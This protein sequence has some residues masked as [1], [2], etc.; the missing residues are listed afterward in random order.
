VTAAGRAARG[1]SNAVRGTFGGTSRRKQEQRSRSST[2]LT[3][4]HAT[5][6]GGMF[7]RDSSSYPRDGGRGRN[8]MWP[9]DDVWLNGRYQEEAGG[10]RPCR[11][12]SGWAYP[13]GGVDTCQG[14]SGYAIS[15]NP[16]PT[17]YSA[18]PIPHK[19]YPIPHTPYTLPNVSHPHAPYPPILYTLYP[20]FL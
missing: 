5:S 19:P 1:L 8:S 18:H 16:Y 10:R 14:F 11:A 4:S 9:C 12:A 17:P 13:L 15:G 3:S 20:V 6:H 7:R 2:P